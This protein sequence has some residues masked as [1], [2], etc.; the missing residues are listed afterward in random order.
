MGRI[1]RHLGKEQQSAVAGKHTINKS[2]LINVITTSSAS[3]LFLDCEVTKQAV[4]EAARTGEV[5]ASLGEGPCGGLILKPAPV[6]GGVADPMRTTHA[7][8]DPLVH[9]TTY[10]CPRPPRSTPP[11]LQQQRRRS[12]ASAVGGHN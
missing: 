6:R 4:R 11:S 5:I 1:I 8:P 2:S 3:F 10:M 9:H 7:P 12:G